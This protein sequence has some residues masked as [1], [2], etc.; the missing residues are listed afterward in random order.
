VPKTGNLNAIAR[1]RFDAVTNTAFGMKIAIWRLRR[2]LGVLLFTLLPCL[3]LAQ[4]SSQ[5]PTE[6]VGLWQGNGF[7]IALRADGTFRAQAPGRALDGHWTRVG[8]HYL[9]T[10]HDE[11]LPKRISR[12]SI[13]G[14]HLIINRPGGT[15]VIHT[16]VDRP[17]QSQ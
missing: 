14:K 5:D 3:T 7:T 8:S 2:A 17:A 16:R 13:H 4:Q 15:T 9:A 10:W 6:L 1:L 11:A 12:Y